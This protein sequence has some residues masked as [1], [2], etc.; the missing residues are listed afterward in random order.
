M[1]KF[2]GDV[3]GKF[4][5]YGKIIKDHPDTIQVGDMGV[6]FFSWPHGEAQ[7]NP[8]YT[9]MV[10]SNA[11]F[12]RG[13][14]DNPAICARH[15]QCIR[16]GHVEGDM[17]F[18][19]GASSIDRMYRIEGFTWWPTEELSQVEMFRIAEIYERT[20]PR[21]MV[22]H[23]APISAIAQIPHTHH[24]G[25]NS[26]TQQ[27]LQSLWNSH[28]PQIWVHGHH[29]ISVDHVLDGTRFICLAELEMKDV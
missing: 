11:R 13:N 23:E 6:G 18:I 3:H 17:M 8:P 5:T 22:T 29:H 21:I 10:A 16:D 27:F 1:V 15:T 20:K 28:K 7:A 14:H 24:F 25:D 9:R 19:G 2:I 12:I 4:S 26:R